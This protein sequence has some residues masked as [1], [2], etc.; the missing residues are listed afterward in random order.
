MNL[1]YPPRVVYEDNHLLI[2]DKPA[3]V[4]SQGDD[5]GDETVL[6]W[7]KRYIKRAYDKPGDVYLG[8]AHRLD[9]PTS[10]LIVMCRT[11]KA[12]G[13]MQ[14]MFAARAVEKTYLA[15]VPVAVQ[16]GERTLI[17]YL[18]HD[19]SVK[20]MRVHDNPKKAG[21]EGKRAELSFEL[22]ARVGAR[23]LLKVRPATG[24]RHQI[25]AQ[26]AAAGMPI[27]GDLRYGAKAPLGD[28]SIGLHAMRLHFRHP[29]GKAPMDVTTLPRERHESF[30]HF[31]DILRGGA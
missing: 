8:L 13:R 12:L 28:K 5:T 26:L 6:D 25:R 16:D 1:R 2:V 18:R 27:E 21:P 3:G 31:V 20:R 4:L 24:R 17:N 29:V 30:R 15:V 14:P 19:P 10:G 23:S 11:S 22:M 7:G 9:R